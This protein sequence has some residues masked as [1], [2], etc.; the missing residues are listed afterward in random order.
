MGVPIIWFL[1][2]KFEYSYFSFIRTF[3]FFKRSYFSFSS[4]LLKLG[5][6]AILSLA[7]MDL[8]GPAQKVDSTVREQ[9][10]IIMIDSS[11]S[12]LVEDVRPNRFKKALLVA[13]HFVKNAYGH[14]ISV[15][16]FSDNEKQLLPFTDDLD[17]IDARLAGLEDLEMGKGGSE[18]S[19][20]LAEAIQYFYEDSA[21]PQGN[22]LILSD[23]EEH[24]SFGELKVP[25][26]ITVAAV[27][28]GTLK[29]DFIPIRE[30]GV[31][32]GYKKYNNENVVSSL[33][34]SV[35]KEFKNRIT[36]YQYWI[37]TSY[38][39]NT[40]EMLDYFT[41]T[42]QSK[43]RKQ[44]S[45]IRPSYGHH[46]VL[47]GVLCLI[48]GCLLSFPKQ[49]VPFLIVAI[50]ATNLNADENA[51]GDQLM[52]RH[53]EGTL[54]K[55]ETL[56]LGGILLRKNENEKSL[57][58]YEENTNDVLKE[59]DEVI[60]N[61]ATGLLKNKKENEAVELYSYLRDKRVEEFGEDDKIV[62]AI[63]NNLL[64]SSNSQ[65][66][67]KQN[68]ESQKKED[69]KNKNDEKNGDKGKGQGNQKNDKQK[70]GENRDKKDQKDKNDGDGK[71]DQN[72]K[73]KDKPED[74]DSK[75]E[76]QKSLKDMQDEIRKAKNSVK[77]PA[78]LK[79]LLNDDRQLQ[80]KLLDAS[81]NDRRSNDGHKDW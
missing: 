42:Y 35:L 59:K 10:T 48:F 75:K 36:N 7:L 16:L 67:K 38:S 76:K 14:Q 81:T 71:K 4:T 55:A 19:K 28:V 78:L 5:G 69:D 73:K 50:F 30:Q 56:K 52:Q 46:L 21:E 15:L 77:I 54:S 80:K 62:Q 32:R 27:G 43:L 58:I 66:Q 49:L 8:R 12:M 3:W 33:S 70:Q 9:K 63:D 41:R 26:G 60:F 61:Y 53:K 39:M 23:F 24:Q 72:E 20:S 25:E 37:S 79:Q 17:L 51:H 64:F 29:G 31:F 74:E 40:S 6:L 11:S 68:K 34:E 57:K 47:V 22:I 45:E 2:W 44:Q 1:V 65:Q 18:I 13:R